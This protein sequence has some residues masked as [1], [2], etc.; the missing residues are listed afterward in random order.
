MRNFTYSGESIT[1]LVGGG[2]C[3]PN[4][5]VSWTRRRRSR[6]HISRLRSMT[7]FLSGRDWPGFGRGGRRWP[8]EGA[9][10]RN[11]SQRATA[12]AGRTGRTGKR[13]KN[14]HNRNTRCYI[15]FLL[16]YARGAT[17]SRSVRVTTM[18]TRYYIL[19][20]ILLLL[21]LYPTF[22]T[23]RNDNVCSII[24]IFT[25]RSARDETVSISYNICYTGD[26]KL[27]YVR[28]KFCKCFSNTFGCIA[29]GDA[30]PL[31]FHKR[32]IPRTTITFI[33]INIWTV[34]YYM[35][36]VRLVVYV[37]RVIFFSF[38]INI[39]NFLFK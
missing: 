21:L 34:E 27:T 2:P 37:L 33:F 19:Y 28:R 4:N 3:A 30:S 32:R 23:G 31:I 9:E 25:Y 12:M 1:I 29:V 16:L 22:S 18:R 35:R 10:R 15:I 17:S 5:N 38:I 14:S 20:Y 13:T 24:I 39:T 11:W 7:V 26:V 36:I 6:H 8:R